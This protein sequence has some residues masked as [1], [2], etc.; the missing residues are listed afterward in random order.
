MAEFNF[1]SNPE[2]AKIF[3][4]YPE[5]VRGYMRKLRDLVINVAE[6]HDEITGLEETLKWGEPSYVTKHGSTLRMDWK[7]RFPNQYAMYF[8]CNSGLVS[9][10]RMV[11]GSDLD[12]EGNRAVILKVDEEYPEAVLR[13]CIE[14]ALRYHKVKKLPMLGM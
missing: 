14:A 13:N 11:H 2:V 12:F 7:Q 5:H 1:K 3:D 4:A 8:N 9:T 6:G 10:F